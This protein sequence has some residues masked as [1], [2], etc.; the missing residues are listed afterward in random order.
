MDDRQLAILTG[1]DKD[2][3]YQAADVLLEAR[4]TLQPIDDLPPALRPKTLEEAYY[5][6]DVMLQALGTVGGWK[7]GAATPEATPLFAPMPLV[8]LA[9]SG[10]SIAKQFRRLR[11][12][13]AEIAFLI[14]KDLP[15]RS[16]PYSRDELVDSIAG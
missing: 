1:A 14:G 13:E 5:V 3:L 11:G 8:G 6:Q 4:R 15:P 9:A 10:D 7:V 16:T 2:R 12:V